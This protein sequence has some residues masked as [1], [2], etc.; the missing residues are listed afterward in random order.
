MI[1]QSR[2]LRRAL[3]L[4]FAAVLGR[5]G[6]AAGE[7]PQVNQIGTGTQS[8]YF[9]MNAREQIDGGTATLAELRHAGIDALVKALGPVGMARFLQRF[10]SGQGDYTAGSDGLT[11]Q[12][13]RQA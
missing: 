8:G 3:E 1:P 11:V 10:G 4:L 9:I 13:A 2:L 5:G 12:R 7:I 6:K